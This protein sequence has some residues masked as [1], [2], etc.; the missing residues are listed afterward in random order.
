[1]QDGDGPEVLS[2]G[3]RGLSVGQRRLR[4][5]IAGLSVVLLAATVV[6]VSIWRHIERPSL[7]TPPERPAVSSE[8]PNRS[9]PTALRGDLGLQLSIFMRPQRQSDR[10][11]G[12][13]IPDARPAFLRSARLAVDAGDF[14][15]YLVGSRRSFC[16][17][18]IETAARSVASSCPVT[19]RDLSNGLAAVTLVSAHHPCGVVASAIPDGYRL[20]SLE[21]PAKIVGAG[22]NGILIAKPGTQTLNLTSDRE[23]SI[24]IVRL[25]SL[26]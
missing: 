11:P 22:P 12:W 20:A 23:P 14:R 3:P 24:T 10:P 26:C 5:V 1:M 21:P 13:A 19:G 16:V 6:T 17:V 7:L 9:I 18:V 15:L 25:G 8:A 2:A 4:W